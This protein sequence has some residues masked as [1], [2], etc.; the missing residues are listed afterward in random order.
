MRMDGKYAAY[1]SILHRHLRPAMGCTEPIAIA[2]AAALARQAL[3]APPD[4]AQ[5]LVSGNI[6][7]NAKSVT[8][9]NTGGR[10]G[11]ET[12]CAA[13]IVAGDSERALEVIAGIT[14]E[15][16]AQVAAFL[17]RD[18]IRVGLKPDARLFDILVTLEGG[19]HSASVRIADR[20]T[21]V[22]SVTRDGAPLRECPASSASIQEETDE[23]LLTVE[24]IYAFASSCDIA[25][26]REVLRHQINCNLRVAEEGLS[27]CWG[28]GVGRTL[29]E[30][31]GDDVCTRAKA[32]AAAGSDARMSGCELPVVINSGS[33]NQGITVSL[34]VII[35]AQALQAQE[36][37][38]YRA[39]VMSNLTAI[40][41]K[42][43]I[44]CLSAY[45]G[46]ISAGCAAGAGIAFLAGGDL[47]LINHTIV[48]GLAILSGTICDGAKPSCAAKVASAV[49]AALMGYHMALS[50]KEF[51]G[52]EGIVKKGVERTIECIGRLGKD[53]MRETDQE[54]LRIMID[55]M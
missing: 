24:E 54:I 13:G 38:L 3:G 15:Q 51:V 47:D 23:A 32:Y 46:A 55:T 16:L 19:G 35:F 10:K 20:H 4:T 52:G 36:E 42:G 17:Q 5:V 7:K 43:L 37:R 45:C 2:Y 14:R 11:I 26:V 50:G 25:D 30:Y 44:G 48:N 41:V 12:A 9:P 29:L 40:R 22:V 6:I 27:G 1:V 49:D 18:C 8:V 33:G 21:H 34:P 28:A 31:G 39:L 53:G